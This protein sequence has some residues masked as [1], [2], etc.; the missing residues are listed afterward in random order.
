[1]HPTSSPS[2]R[3]AARA[4]RAGAVLLIGLLA[5]PAQAAAPKVGT[6]APAFSAAGSD[7][8]PHALADY[9]G[10]YVV[11][12]WTNADCPFVRKH[13]DSGNMQALQKAAAADG[14][15]WLSVVSSAP[16]A[17]G[18]VD[19]ATANALTS[20]RE[21]APATVLLDESGSLG[22]LYAAKTTPHLF[23][24]DPQGVLIYAGAIDDTPSAD[25]EDVRAA[26]NY[27]K[28]ALAEA[29]AGQPVSTPVT[30][31]YGCSVKYAR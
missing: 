31:P 20:R 15:A 22:R 25:P 17:Q 14:V 28:A 4:L 13:Y 29:R 1:M 21:A 6:P 23:V 12:E 26:K 5:A 10:R 8:R 11:L 24:I 3:P 18:H 30:T 19:A 27:V 7:G 2:L 16:G 9:R